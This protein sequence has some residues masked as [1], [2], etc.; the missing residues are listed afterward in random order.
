VQN[1]ILVSCPA[2]PSGDWASIVHIGRYACFAG[3][4][5][6]RQPT[7]GKPSPGF[8]TEDETENLF[9]KYSQVQAAN[10][11]MAS[12]QMALVDIMEGFGMYRPWPSLLLAL[13]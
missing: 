7:S 11:A 3:K 12:A 2:P 10:N 8:D 13:K 6:A 5:P 9:A 1:P 4:V